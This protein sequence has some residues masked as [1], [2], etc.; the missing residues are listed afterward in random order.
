VRVEVPS[1]LPP[2]AS[3]HLKKIAVART[4]K[5]RLRLA[6]DPLQLSLGGAFPMG[7]K[8]GPGPDDS[9]IKHA[10]EHPAVFEKEAWASGGPM[11]GKISK[12]KSN[13]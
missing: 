13:I 3:S 5:D 1:V 7:D 8:R 11:V 4:D 10:N 12:F 6:T 9:P 2:P